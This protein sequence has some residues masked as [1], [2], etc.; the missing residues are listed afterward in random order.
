MTC[1]T[2]IAAALLL[3][4]AL[5]VAP[6]VWAEEAA[7]QCACPDPCAEPEPLIPAPDYRGS[8]WCRQKLS[9][10][11]CG[12]RGRLARKGVFLDV[13]WVQISQGIL[14]GGRRERWGHSTNLDLLAKFDLQRL[15]V[16][17]GAL[18]SLRTQSRF[19]GTVNA[20]S[21][22]LLPVNTAGYFPVTRVIDDDVPIAI[23]ELYWTQMLSET[24]GVFFGKITT[25]GGMNEFAGGEGITQFMNFQFLF[26]ATLAQLVPYSNLAA[27][28]LWMP[29]PRLTIS[30]LI[31][32]TAEAS[33][34]TG[35]TDF[36]EGQTWWTSG[37][38]TWKDGCCRPGGVTLGGGYAFGGDFARVGGLNIDPTGGVTLRTKSTT[39]AAYASG[40]Q[41]LVMCE[42]P[43]DIDPTDGVQELRGLGVFAKLGIGDKD[44]NPVQW[45]VTAGVS[46]RGL[47]PG[48]CN[49]TFGVGYFYNEIGN[50]VS[51]AL[52]ALLFDRETQGVEAYYRFAVAPSVGI[53]VDAQWTEDAVR[54]VRSAFLLGFRLHVDF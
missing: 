25:M 23:T 31:M 19:G 7:D 24:F 42:P 21:G 18:V 43:R 48:R 12:L 54:T 33:T 26:P 14:D 17:P 9:G 52:A 13:R 22:L 28:V 11:W 34:T 29:S 50:P 6:H 51:G 36:D 38:F 37:T 49:D 5:A 15:G 45:S 8:I 32:N 53:T 46:G 20:D 35:F 47:I 4:C 40:W 10:D 44:S 39:W 27:G 3:L 2:T 1:P 16:V 41:Y 30:S